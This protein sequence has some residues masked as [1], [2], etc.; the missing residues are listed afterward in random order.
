[1]RFA[2]DTPLGGRHG[3]IATRIAVGLFIIAA[4]VGP[5]AASWISGWAI[6]AMIVSLVLML[7]S[8]VRDRRPQHEL[9]GTAKPED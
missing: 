1:M 3:E 4:I 5:P 8:E 2:T 9:S 6:V 7:V